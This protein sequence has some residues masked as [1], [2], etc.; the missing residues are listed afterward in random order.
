MRPLCRASFGRP[1]GFAD[2]FLHSLEVIDLSASFERHE[3]QIMWRLRL[4]YDRREDFRKLPLV[5]LY[6]NL[7]IREVKLDVVDAIPSS[8]WQRAVRP[9]NA[10]FRPNPALR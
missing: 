3:G 10:E 7:D 8:P 9:I 2:G 1:F 6:D 5:H 4:D